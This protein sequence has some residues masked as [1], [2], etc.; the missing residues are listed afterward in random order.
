MAVHSGAAQN[1][2]DKANQPYA[3]HAYIYIYIYI[4][5]EVVQREEGIPISRLLCLRMASLS[6]M[7]LSEIMKTLLIKLSLMNCIRGIIY[8]YIYII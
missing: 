1:I 5:I 3:H 8:I 4:Y 6:T 7:D 2:V